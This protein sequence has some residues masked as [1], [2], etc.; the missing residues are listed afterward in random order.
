M[1]RAGVAAGVTEE[2]VLAELSEAR[3]ALESITG[4]RSSEDLLRYIFGR[5]CIGK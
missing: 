1:A 2:V 3:V 5:F 4:R